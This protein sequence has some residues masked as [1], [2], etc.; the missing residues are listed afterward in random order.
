[1]GCIHELVLVV[2]ADHCPLDP[3]RVGRSP[4]IVGYNYNMKILALTPQQ[5]LGMILIFLR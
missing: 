3:P 4:N 1:M 2:T 5:L